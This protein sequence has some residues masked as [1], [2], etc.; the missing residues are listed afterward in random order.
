MRRV[1]GLAP[2]AL[3]LVLVGA[4]TSV[5]SSQASGGTLRINLQADTDAVDPALAYYPV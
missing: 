3:V 2:L 4:G 5:A 1:P